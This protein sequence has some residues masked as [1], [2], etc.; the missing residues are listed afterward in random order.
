MLPRLTDDQEVK[1]NEKNTPNEKIIDITLKNYYASFPKE[2]VLKT[3][4]KNAFVINRPLDQVGGDGYWLHES[5]GVIFLVVFD[6][7]G[8]GRLASIMTRIYIS[9][10]RQT[11]QDDEVED[12]GCIL[13]AIHN[14]IKAYFE[15]KKNTQ[16]GSGADIGILKLDAHNSKIEYAGSKMDLVYTHQGEVHRIKANKRQVG[17]LFDF[18]RDY[19][20]IV[21]DWK[22]TTAPANIYLF[23]DGVTD[24][25]GGAQN[26]KLKFKGFQRMLEE[27]I[28]QSFGNHKKL[29]EE[30]LTKW[31]GRNHQTDDLLLIGLSVTEDYFL[32]TT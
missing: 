8:H 14:R 30:K 25:I 24:L 5:H 17:D 28:D 21:L 2:S 22:R 27:I 16:I 18:D 29:L 31:S 20:T 3:L 4:L 32:A 6:C 26:K 11:I 19:T 7:M 12:P 13:T 10:I 1:S 15:S 9:A 23:S